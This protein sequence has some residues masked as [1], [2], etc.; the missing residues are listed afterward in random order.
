[1]E[2]VISIAKRYNHARTHYKDPR[3]RGAKGAK[4]VLGIYVI[5]EDGKLQFKKIS[6]F[7]I[8]YYRTKLWKR[9]IY[10]CSEC[11]RKFMALVKK[12]TD[13]VV[14]PFCST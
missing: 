9:R 10:V 2:Y 1:M 3:N 6:R 13:Y 14:C 7:M 8:P 4:S 5:N 12:H 11:D